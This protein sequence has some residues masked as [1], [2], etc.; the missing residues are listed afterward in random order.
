MLFNPRLTLYLSNVE[1]L[2]YFEHPRYPV[3][4]GRSQDLMTYTTV[5]VLNLERA[6]RAFYA[7]TL[8]PLEQAAMLGGRFFAVTMPRFIDEYRRPTWTQYGVLHDPVEYPGEQTLQMDEDELEILIDPDYDHDPTTRHPYKAL[9]RG[10]IW[11][12]WENDYADHPSP[13]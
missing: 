2:P 6:N 7:G 12:T 1:L 3:L 4:L 11:H 13:S 5:K 8:V 10:V 9:Q